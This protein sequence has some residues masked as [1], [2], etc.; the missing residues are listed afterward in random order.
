M[1]AFRELLQPTE[2][3]SQGQSLTLVSDIGILIRHAFEGPA[4]QV[5][6]VQP[7]VDHRRDPA[8]AFELLDRAAAAFEV[9]VTRCQR[10]EAKM[11][12]DAERAGAEAAAQNDVIEQW[13]KLGA[14]M[15]AHAEETEKKLQAMKARAET[16]EVRATAAEA[17]VASL[18]QASAAAARQAVAAETL[19][20][21]FHDKVIATF[22]IGS[23]A[24]GALEIATKVAGALPSP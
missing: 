18:E 20:T 7:E 4:G 13:R 17:R 19:S 23:R 15:K 24:Y 3:G 5:G 9:L 6:P 22:G 11:I 21:E 1:A 2:R 14:G 16:A 12:E 10:L 8:M